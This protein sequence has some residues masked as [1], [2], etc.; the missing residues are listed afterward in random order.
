ML[1]IFAEGFLETPTAFGVPL[2]ALLLFF[3]VMR[4]INESKNSGRS[5]QQHRAA[6]PSRVATAARSLGAGFAAST[7]SIPLIGEV[8]DTV[9][10]FLS[11]GFKHEGRRVVLQ[12]RVKLHESGSFFVAGGQHESGSLSR[13]HYG[14]TM[15]TGTAGETIAGTLGCP[16]FSTGRWAIGAFRDVND[17]ALG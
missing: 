10:E 2:G 6:T 15:V 5:D 11:S 14:C 12:F 9:V 1:F 17:I 4:A 16:G 13:S 3:W 7:E 8:D